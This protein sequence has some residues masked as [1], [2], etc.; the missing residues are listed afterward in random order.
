MPD[1]DLLHSR[2]QSAPEQRPLALESPTACMGGCPGPGLGC[3]CSAQARPRGH[4]HRGGAFHL[5]AVW[6]SSIFAFPKA[7]PRHKPG[8]YVGKEENGLWGGQPCALKTHSLL[9]KALGH[10]VRFHRSCL[11]NS[12][13]AQPGFQTPCVIAACLCSKCSLGR[14]QDK[15]IIKTIIFKLS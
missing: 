1:V 12:N 8:T 3:S 10:S 9:P 5:L 15:Y 14:Y 13:A 11:Q 6:D 7:A 4:A 2:C